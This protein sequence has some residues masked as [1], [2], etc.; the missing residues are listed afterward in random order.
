MLLFFNIPAYVHVNP[1]LPVFTELVNRGHHVVYYNSDTFEQVTAIISQEPRIAT[2][3]T[4]GVVR[5]LCIDP[6]QFEGIL[7]ERPEISLAVMRVLCRR[8]KE[9]TT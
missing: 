1:T 9:A 2:L 5:T 3:I 4:T 7:R 6:K 8:L